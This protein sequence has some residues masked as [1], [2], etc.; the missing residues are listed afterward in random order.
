MKAWVQDP[1]I[2][3]ELSK[4]DASDRARQVYHALHD[5]SFFPGVRDIL[6]IIT[7]I[8]DEIIKAEGDQSSISQVIPRWT[9]V[10]LHLELIASSSPTVNWSELW[11]KL[12][13]RRQRQLTPLHSL[14]YWMTPATI[15]SGEYMLPALLDSCLN[16]LARYIEPHDLHTAQKTFLSYKNR[17]GNFAEGTR[18]WQ[19]VE[20]PE[21]F[22][23]LH[24]GE[25]PA[26]ATLAYRLQHT[27]A[28][29]VPSER[30]FSVMK[31][32]KSKTR[33]KLNDE[34]TN[35]LLFIQ[36]NLRVLSRS[37]KNTEQT[38]QSESES[39]AEEDEDTNIP[40]IIAP[41][42]A[43]EIQTHAIQEE[44]RPA[45]TGTNWPLHDCRPHL[46]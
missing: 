44:E 20:D 22:W 4:P 37:H 43:S 41:I 25:C 13:R 12:L 6:N 26:L 21:T 17:T 7:P 16:T 29:E 15:T 42:E 32:L 18:G 39:E 5:P 10:W 40:C 30:A 9:R 38:N 45:Y 2:K 24:H 14:A 3:H 34:R 11:N 19:F 23:Q 31:L 28:N 27:L 1:V 33:N 46:D 35:M 8:V 36:M